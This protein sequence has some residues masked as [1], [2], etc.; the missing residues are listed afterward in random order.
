MKYDPEAWR[1]AQA[2]GAAFARRDFAVAR[3]LAQQ[4]LARRPLDP[5]GNQIL[6]L[7]GLEEGD[8]ATAKRHL[9]R[10]NQAAPNQPPIMNALGVALRRLGDVD[11]AR[12]LFT[13]AGEGG[14]IDGWRNL[15]NLENGARNAAASRA[16]FQRALK[17]APNDAAAHA[18]LARGYEDEHDLANAKLH[19]EAALRADPS[20]EIARIALAQVLLREKDFAGAEAAA[21]PVVKNPAAAA[22]N[23]TLAW[24]LIG[25][26]RDRQSDAH[27]AF[28]AYTSA[29][30]ILL[31]QNE[32]LLHAAH[33]LYHPDGVARMTAL[34][35]ATDS[36]SWRPNASSVQPA[37]VFLVG[38]PRSGTT[39][40][41]Q[42]LSSHS[43]IFCI[44]E[45]EHFANA[46]ASVITDEAKLAA[47]AM[48]S[49][50]EIEA[51]RMDYW[52]RVH[53]EDAPP[54]GALVV[55]KLP[56]NI[57]V[58]PLIKRVFP[59]AKIIFA[60][61]DPRDVIL[62]CYVQRFGMN[63]AMAQFLDLSRAA[64]YYDAIMR[65]MTRCREKLA[66]DLHQVRYEDVVA[67]LEGQARALTAFL[68]VAF[69][70]AM[71]SFR[72]TALARDINTPSARQ[73]IEPIYTRS[74][75]K[76]RRYVGD[77][78]PILPLLTAWAE[79]FGYTA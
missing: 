70:P 28:A 4:V 69:E 76:W 24:G 9:D 50:A 47:F 25:D 44:E 8:F 59:D 22:T 11:A 26:A 68:G 63:A 53:A 62:S 58:L 5:N 56:L 74:I 32:A 60:L 52:R 45:R 29:N 43:G 2:A 33:L 14:L 31:K 66:L 34:L 6:G 37:P 77:L 48:L 10:A 65:L 30:Q 61:R 20:N 42:I 73:V 23:A 13:R 19:A 72:E 71:L 1:L 18:G 38:F 46:L 17:I 15:G 41:D 49:D 64:A 12:P 67:D 35:A 27:G 75:G 54:E 51:A 40:L 39:L 7:I 55:D 36:A 57:V 21:L 16:A 79:R 3:Q 78:A